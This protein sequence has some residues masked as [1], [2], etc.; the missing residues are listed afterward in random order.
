MNYEQPP[1]YT[2]PGPTAPGYPPPNAPGYPAQGYPP[3]GFPPQGYPAQGYQGFPAQ[4]DQPNPGYPNY[5]PGPPGSFPVQPGCQGYP[6]QQYGGPMYG[7]P[8]KNTVYVVEQGRREDSGDQACLT[9][10]WTA[11]CCCCLWD[12]LT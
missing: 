1:P 10:C 2:G 4:T 7:E 12:M 6:Q 8:P 5:P 11:L 3:Q 9:A